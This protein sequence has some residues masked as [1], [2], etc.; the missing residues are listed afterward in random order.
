MINFATVIVMGSLQSTSPSLLRAASNATA[1]FAISSGPNAESFSMSARIGTFQPQN[2]GG[3]IA[4]RPRADSN[5]GRFSSELRTLPAFKI[6]QENHRDGERVPKRTLVNQSNGRIVHARKKK[7]E[8]LSEGQQD[9]TKGSW[10]SNAAVAPV[11][12]NNFAHRAGEIIATAAAHL[13]YPA[14]RRRGMRR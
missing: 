12:D 6:N 2:T 9:R 1:K 3:N 10:K 11:D 8:H 4:V 5:L 7:R 13:K 14:R